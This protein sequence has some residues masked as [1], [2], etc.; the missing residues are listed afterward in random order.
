MLKINQGGIFMTIKRWV[1]WSALIW[2]IG[3]R[4]SAAETLTV[5]GKQLNVRSGPGRTYDVVEVVGQD[6]KFEILAQQSGWYQISVEG[7]VGWISGKAVRLEADTD[8][9]AL[10][11]QADACFDR[12]Q[13]TTPPAANAFDLYQQVLQRDPDN[14]RARRKLAQMA[15]RY[16]LW[17]EKA[18][19][20]GEYQKA[21]IFYQRY[22]FVNPDDAEV[23]N[24]LQ[25]LHNPALHPDAALQILSLR[26]TPAAVSAAQVRQ[27]ISRHGF[28]HPADWSAYG[29]S[30][31]I[32]GHIQHDYAVIQ[33]DKVTVVKDY[34]TTLMWQQSGPAD[35]LTWPRARQ[36]V[37]SLNQQ[38]YAGFTDWRLP[39][40]EELASLLE[41][42]QPEGQLYLA[43]VFG[44]T[45]LWCWSADTVAGADGAAWYISFT[46]GGVQRQAL[47]ST[48]FVLAVRSLPSSP[49]Q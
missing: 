15:A 29:L 37:V 6:E 31:S 45:P 42:A 40:L 20:Q 47:S 43:P 16:K 24:F 8:V 22:A 39:T 27:L 34:A 9:Q 49:G 28:H 33:I 19:E 38:A 26:K 30:G 11:E 10:L 25:Q 48:A 23:Q 35:P 2:L 1:R 18:A 21:R 32:T 5:I 17:A 14:A 41:A 13:F 12:L 4:L 7:Q 3:C 44:S 46:S 36:Y